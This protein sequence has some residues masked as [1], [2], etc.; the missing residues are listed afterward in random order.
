M[1]TTLLGRVVL[2]GT[3]NLLFPSKIV[4]NERYINIR[5][6]LGD[7]RFLQEDVVSIEEISSSCIRIRHIVVNYPRYVT[8]SCE[9]IACELKKLNFQPCADSNVWRRHHPHNLPIKRH[10][11][12]IHIVV[13]ILLVFNPWEHTRYAVVI[14]T[15]LLYVAFFIS[16]L[17]SERSQRIFLKPDNFNDDQFKHKI[18][19]GTVLL[20]F[21]FP[22]VIT[23]PYLCE[24]YVHLCRQRPNIFFGF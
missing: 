14:L 18:M 7:Y 1:P 2:G 3:S 17:I 8:F 22:I 23:N 4:I 5:A 16:V 19:V 13:C 12:L 11:V 6:F 10:F 24:K 15:Y 20:I 9:N 21:F